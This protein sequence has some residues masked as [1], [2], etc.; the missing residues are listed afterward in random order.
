MTQSVNNA[1]KVNSPKEEMP[2]EKRI[3]NLQVSISIAKREIKDTLTMLPTLKGDEKKRKVERL[4]QLDKI[5]ATKEN[6]LEPLKAQRGKNGG[7]R[8]KVTVSQSDMT[9]TMERYKI[10]L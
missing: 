4:A 9:A 7:H 8:S 6:E 3:K 1:Q 2:L 10:T 5:I